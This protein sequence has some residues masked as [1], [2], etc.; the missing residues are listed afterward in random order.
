[1]SET[2]QFLH[3]CKAVPLAA[4]GSPW[5]DQC[6]ISDIFDFG[7]CSLAASAENSFRPRV[8]ATKSRCGKGRHNEH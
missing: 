6:P 4:F 2:D 5:P 3:T 1:M 8:Q 7:Q